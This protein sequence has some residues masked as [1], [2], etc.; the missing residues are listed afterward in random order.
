MMFRISY[1]D[2]NGL[3]CMFEDVYSLKDL[4]NITIFSLGAKLDIRV[5]CYMKAR[6]PII[7]LIKK[8]DNIKKSYQH[9][10]NKLF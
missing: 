7:A 8:Y 10:V 5:Y 9:Y 3:E 4:Y 6:L 2:S 1:F